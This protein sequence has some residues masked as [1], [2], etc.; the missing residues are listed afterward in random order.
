MLGRC[1]SEI[2]ALASVGDSVA[3]YCRPKLVRREKIQDGTIG[4]IHMLSIHKA[5]Q[6][7]TTA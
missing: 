4:R 2:V 3:C 7:Y 5:N 6:V 1:G